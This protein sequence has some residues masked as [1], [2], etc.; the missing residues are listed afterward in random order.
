MAEGHKNAPLI[1]DILPHSRAFRAGV[2][3]GDLLVSINR[4]PVRDRLDMMFLSGEPLREICIERDGKRRTLRFQPCDRS[5]VSSL[6]I[7]ELHPRTCGNNC[8][9]CFVSQLPRG[10]RRTL[11]F[12]DEDYR[13][14]FLQGNYITA[15]NLK[16]DDIQRILDQKLSPL[17]ISVHATEPLLRKALLGNSRCP[18][19]MPLL[20]RLAMGGIAFHTQIVLMPGIND[21]DVLKRTIGELLEL[22]KNLLSIAV[23]PVGLTCHRKKLP[24]LQPVDAAYARALIREMRPMQKITALRQGRDSLFLSDEFFLLAGMRPPAY[25]GFPEI[26]QL[27]NG[28]GMVASFYRGFARSLR[29][30][31]RKVHPPVTVALVTAPLGRMAISR[32]LERMK[33]IAGL[34]LEAVVVQN[35]LLGPSVTV[36]GL[37]AGG[38]VLRALRGYKNADLYLLPEN[39]V[40]ADGVMLDDMS[41][42]DMERALGRPVLVAPSSARGI[43]GILKDYAVK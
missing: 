6:F 25:A 4:Q 40:N 29:W 13:L 27:E 15:V 33:A 41:P 10:M 23:V 9:F 38:D 7:E 8:I 2:R 36:S 32:F 20:K 1:N 31:P 35:N 37:M 14:S 11:Y 3:P 30:F 26:P 34:T 16:E 18:D 21:G 17:Y 39:C 19:I 12:K 43:L 28:V 24:V 22:G 42:A 5:G